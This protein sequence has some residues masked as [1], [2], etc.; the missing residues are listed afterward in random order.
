MCK[1]FAFGAAFE[2]AF[3]NT[4]QLRNLN[5]HDVP[6]SLVIIGLLSRWEVFSASI[7]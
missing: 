6:L 5:V 7:M 4:P 3:P 2:T 1:A